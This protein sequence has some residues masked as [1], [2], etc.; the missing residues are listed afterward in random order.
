MIE[1]KLL[2]DLGVSYDAVEDKTVWLLSSS[3]VSKDR[4]DH[5]VETGTWSFDEESIESLSQNKEN[6]EK[7]IKDYRELLKGAKA[8][9]LVVL[10]S[11]TTVKNQ[12]SVPFEMIDDAESVT[13]VK[14]VGVIK[15]N[16]GD[17]NSLDIKWVKFNDIKKF[18]F[19]YPA[20][21]IVPIKYKEEWK[22]KEFIN[23]VFY[24]V[25]QR[26]EKFINDKLDK[27]KLSKSK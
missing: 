12:E 17:G 7:K 27:R 6:T 15:S 22:D 8:G 23:F 4:V 18:Y 24:D 10:K 25:P 9:E 11:T 26:F 1:Y 13:Y 5:L 20:K 14:A 19:Y 16:P 3:R 2:K 21:A